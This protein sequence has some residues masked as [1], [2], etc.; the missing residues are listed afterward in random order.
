MLD[1]LYEESLDDVASAQRILSRLEPMVANEIRFSTSLSDGKCPPADQWDA[2]ASVDLFPSIVAPHAVLDEMVAGG[3]MSA[4]RDPGLREAIQ[5][6]RSDLDF[7]ARQNEFF[8]SKHETLLRSGDPRMTLRFDQ[9]KSE[10][11]TPAFD[12][13]GL[14]A[15]H[16]FRNAMIN[17]TRDQLVL[18]TMRK[19]NAARARAMCTALARATGNRCA[20]S[21]APPRP[22][23]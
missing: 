8:R 7:A 11:V 20:P 22:S 3:G 4:I 21:P 1:R 10:S 14:C 2:V 6:Y 9:A 5:A 13:A 23:S 15:D 18:L 19:R 16:G 12:T 17:A